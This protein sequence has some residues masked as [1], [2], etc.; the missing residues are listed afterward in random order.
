MLIQ[1]LKYFPGKN[2]RDKVLKSKQSSVWSPGWPPYGPLHYVKF[3]KKI[4][5]FV[6]INMLTDQ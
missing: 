3:K 2:P 6:D 4:V 1:I 5:F